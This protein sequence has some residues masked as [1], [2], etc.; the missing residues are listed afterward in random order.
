V[1]NRDGAGTGTFPALRFTAAAA[2]AQYAVVPLAPADGNRIPSTAVAL[3]VDVSNTAGGNSDV[4]FE[5]AT[6]SGFTAVV[7]ATT[8]TDV[9]DGQRSAVTSGLVSG[10]KYWWRAR[11]APTGTTDWGPWSGTA[12]ISIPVTPVAVTAATALSALDPAGNAVDGNVATHW[13]SAG[14]MPTWWRAQF[15]SAQAIT[16]MTLRNR[17]YD[18]L[19]PPR[20]F[21]I[22]GSN[23][24]TAWTTLSTQTGVTWSPANELKTF[25]WSNSTAYLYA[26]VYVTAANGAN[27]QNWAEVTF[28]AAGAPVVVFDPWAFTPDLNAGRGFAYVDSNLGF[29]PVLDADVTGAA[30]VDLN[31]GA[32]LVLDRDVTGAAYVDLNVGVQITLDADGVE[33]GHFGDVTT[34]P[35]APHVWFLRPAAGRAGDGISIVCFG[36]GDLVGTYAGS[37]ELDYG[38]TT[39]WVSVPVTAWNTFPPGPDAYTAAR[40]LDEETGYIDMQH[41]VVEIVIPAGAVPP[42]Y[43]LRI[44]TVTP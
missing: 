18:T 33:Y 1:V 30:Y 7:W 17:N 14:E 34:D 38:G 8:V 24:G 39:G 28:S 40:R 5:V 26:R 36:V 25:N 3:V 13:H 9:P 32:D 11:L 15:G 12:R 4:R 42:G 31:V 37:V 19:R 23:D 10:T 21:L 35:P 43:P 41:T 20:D 2:T 29:N 22:Q 6:D 27:Y 16:Q 44:R